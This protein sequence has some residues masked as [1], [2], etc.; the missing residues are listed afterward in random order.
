MS[1]LAPACCTHTTSAHGDVML[2]LYGPSVHLHSMCHLLL[3]V[4]ILAHILLHALSHR[5]IMIHQPATAHFAV[6]TAESQLSHSW[7]TAESTSHL[8]LTCADCPAGM[9]FSWWYTA[10]CAFSMLL[11]TLPACTKR[12]RRPGAH[13]PF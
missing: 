12:S 1:M 7:V 10:T 4:C 13:S 8:L 3:K 11:S 5:L 6:V 9:A 2:A